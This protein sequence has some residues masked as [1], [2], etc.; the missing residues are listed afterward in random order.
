MDYETIVNCFVGVFEHYKDDGVKHLFV[1][2]HTRNDLPAFVK[3]LERNVANKEW[4]ISFN[5]LAFDGQISQYILDNKNRLLKMKTEDVIADLYAFSQKTIS[6]GNTNQFLTYSPRKIKIR[7]LDLFKMNHWDNQAKRSSLKWVQYSMDWENIEE[8]PHPHYLPITTQ[9]ELEKVIKYCMNDVSSTKNIMVHSK[10][11]IKLRQTLT[12]EYGIDLYSASEPRISKELFLH[13]LSQ[14]TGID[15]YTIKDMRTPRSHIVLGDCILPNIEFKTPEFQQ[16]LNFFRKTVVTSTKDGFKYRLNYKGVNTDYGLGGLHGATQAGVYEATPGWTIMTS[17]VTSFYPNLAIRNMFAPEHLPKGDFCTLYEWFFEERKKI[18]KTD[19]KNYVFKIILNSTYGLSG[20]PNSFLYDPKFTMQITV[21]GQLLLSKLYEMLS[22]AIPECIPL[23]QNTDGLEM[24]IPTSKIDTYM[25]VCEEWQ[26]L[27][28]LEL[29]HDQY[30]K[31]IIRDVNNYIAITIPKKVKDDKDGTPAKTVW[32]TMKKKTPSYL[33]FEKNGDFFYQATKCK[34]A[35]E[36]EDLAKKK[37][38]SFH[39]N[40]S[41]LII[42]KAIYAYF[43]NG[44]RPEDFLAQNQDVMDYCAGVKAKGDWKIKKME[45]SG[46]ILTEEILQKITRY[47]ISNSGGKLVKTHPDGREIQVEAGSW[48]QKVVNR[49]DPKAPFHSYD[50]NLNYYLE[51][52]FS[53]IEQIEKFKPRAFKQLSL[54]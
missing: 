15:K 32:E 20:D 1:I 42:P 12:R 36:W 17:D 8:M 16:V 27:T 5:G 48:L 26:K 29:E 41:F 4:H 10:E 46:G 18:P 19:P 25:K 50:I 3:F 49:I 11:Q 13:F 14:K 47:Y 23:M 54:F 9:E 52:I 45:V 6:L 22:L 35:F 31:M 39:K 21:N 38:A 24:M 40:K 44:T 30:K 43:V 28:K 37:I 2:H 33:Y 7:Q 34:G 53:Q 51:E